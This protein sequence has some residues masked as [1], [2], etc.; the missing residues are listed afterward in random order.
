MVTASAIDLEISDLPPP[1]TVDGLWH[2]VLRGAVPMIVH[3][4]GSWRTYR[5]VTLK[6]VVST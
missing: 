4:A 2:T 5:I 1:E 3:W 6:P